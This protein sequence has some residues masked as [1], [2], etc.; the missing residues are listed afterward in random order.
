MLIRPVAIIRVL[1]GPMAIIA[2]ALASTALAKPKSAPGSHDQARDLIGR[3]SLTRLDQ[4]EEKGLTQARL[5]IQPWSGDYWPIYQGVLGQRYGDPGFPASTDWKRNRD[6][7]LTR[8]GKGRPEHLSPAEKYDLW[9]GNPNFMLTRRMWAQ[10]QAHYSQ[11]GSVEPWMGICHGWAPAAFMVDR[12]VK[13][14]SVLSADGQTKIEFSASDIKG[15]VSQLWASGEFETDFIGGR[16]EL[17]APGDRRCHDTNPATWHLS[18]VH[19]LGLE[20]KSLVMD[21]AYDYEVWNHPVVAYRYQY[22]N[23]KT[24]RGARYIRTATVPLNRFPTDPHRGFRAENAVEVV[25]I[26]MEVEF[27]IESAA[28]S[29]EDETQTVTYE[30]DLELDATGKIVGGEWYSTHEH[31]DFLWTPKARTKVV[32]VGDALIADQ[33]W[34]GRGV[35][36]VA[37][38]RAARLSAKDGMPLGRLVDILVRASRAER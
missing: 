15:L 25:G 5:E 8:L 36:P 13:P 31:P 22:F 35:M 23:P 4:I 14:V 3:I 38:R 10:G 37:F 26:R 18:V 6:Y 28:G 11:S 17:Q 21:A 1:L 2:F 29:D 12:P 30:Y 7:A 34:S 20:G 33:R 9:T 27:A 19:R 32:S 16:C 24:K